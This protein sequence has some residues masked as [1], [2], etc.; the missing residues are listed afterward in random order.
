MSFE[1]NCNLTFARRAGRK[2]EANVK[3]TLPATLTQNGACHG[4]FHVPMQKSHHA[5][6]RA[7]VWLLHPVTIG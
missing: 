6:A 7:G 1:W 5:T 3:F 2:Q 4:F